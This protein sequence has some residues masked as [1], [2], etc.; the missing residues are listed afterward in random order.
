LTVNL[1]F[2]S[3]KSEIKARYS[4]RPTCKR[5]ERAKRNSVSKQLSSEL[6][7]PP[8]CG[9]FLKIK[10][11]GIKVKVNGSEISYPCPV[12]IGEILVVDKFGRDHYRCNNKTMDVQLVEAKLAI[13]LF[14]LRQIPPSKHEAR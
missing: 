10:L 11:R 2:R 6:E 4:D 1:L 3:F 9:P 7:I 14:E 12:L 5:N 13:V 8:T